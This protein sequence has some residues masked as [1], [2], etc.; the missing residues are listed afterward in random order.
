MYGLFTQ[1]VVIILTLFSFFS[2]S[3]CQKEEPPYEYPEDPVLTDPELIIH[4]QRSLRSGENWT[5]MSKEENCKGSL[6]TINYAYYNIDTSR[7]FATMHLI[8]DSSSCNLQVS[9]ETEI[10]DDEISNLDW[11]DLDFE[12]TF[13][14]LLLN[15]DSELWMRLRYKEFEMNIDFAPL[16]LDVDSNIENGVL[17][18]FQ[19]S[20]GM[21]YWVNGIKVNP[22]FGL[23]GNSE[24]TSSSGMDP[25]FGVDLISEGADEQSLL[26][27][28]YLR[29]TS[30][31]VPEP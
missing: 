7:G 10:G 27:F 11:A 13:S 14:E 30:L 21:K 19:D 4:W 15:S 3:G 24:S 6:S 2:F 1:R 20:D 29:I 18:I 25:F 26:V 16:I 8:P 31:T 17:K 23:T 5:E 9:L 22:D 28:Q 12:F